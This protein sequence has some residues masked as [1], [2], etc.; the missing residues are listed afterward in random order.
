MLGRKLLNTH[1]YDG[2]LNRNPNLDAKIESV[3]DIDENEKRRVILQ[4]FQQP[5]NKL[6]KIGNEYMRK[7]IDDMIHPNGKVKNFDGK[8]GL[9]AG[10]VLYLIC[11]NNPSRTI[12]DVINVQF[13]DMR[14]GLCPQGRSTRL[15]QVLLAI[16]PVSDLEVQ[17]ERGS[18]ITFVDE[19]DETHEFELEFD[20]GDTDDEEEIIEIDL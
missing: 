20:D 10:D 15:Y 1:F 11:K 7:V 5:K 18:N 14:T 2:K 4:F 8:N 17:S 3:R 19:D 13:E 9:W 12:V 16:A 6:S